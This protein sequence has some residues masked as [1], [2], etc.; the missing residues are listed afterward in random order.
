M[1]TAIV[2]TVVALVTLPTILLAMGLARAAAVEHRAG[3]PRPGARRTRGSEMG[4]SAFT[5]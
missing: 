3:S 1:I 5:R 2:V 4:V